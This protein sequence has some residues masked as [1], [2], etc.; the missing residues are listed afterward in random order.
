MFDCYQQPAILARLGTL[1]QPVVRSSTV[2]IALTR[3]TT[4]KSVKRKSHFPTTETKN[5]T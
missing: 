1:A 5:G 3:I 4:K 2:V